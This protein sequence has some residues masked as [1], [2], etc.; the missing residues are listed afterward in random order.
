MK[1]LLRV[2][3]ALFLL[4]G[5]SH[6]V[7]AV[8]SSPAAVQALIP[9]E[10]RRVLAYVREHRAAPP[11]HVGGR[12]FGNFE[13]RLPKVDGR[14]GRVTYQEWDIFPKTRG[15]N[16]G[17]QRLVTGSDGR[18]WYTGDH[19]ASFTELKEPR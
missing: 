13:G 10:A 19:Y 7:P 14:G 18:A 3:A 6:A 4:A 12:R 11:G 16:R 5:W 8:P 15:R 17:A 2:L 9:P 1:L